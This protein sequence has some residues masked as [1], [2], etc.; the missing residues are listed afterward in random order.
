MPLRKP[1]LCLDK[2]LSRY[3][4]KWGGKRRWLG[5][6]KTVARERYAAEIAAWGRWVGQREAEKLATSQ[7]RSRRLSSITD[8][9]EEFIETKRLEGT[10][11]YTLVFYRHT[12]S[13]F[14]S[15]WGAY[16]PDGFRVQNLLG[17]KKK[18]LL[19][20]LAPRTVKHQLDCI[21][22][23]FQFGADMEF[24]EPKNLRRCKAPALPEPH[25]KA[26]SVQELRHI[27]EIVPDRVRPWVIAQYAC[28]M[29][30]SEIIRV[31][32]RRGSWVEDGVFKLDKSKSTWRSKQSRHIIV[33]T[34]AQAWLDR[35]APIFSTLSG[36][37]TAFGR[38]RF[39]DPETQKQ[40]SV[41][42]IEGGPHPLR[43]SSATHLLQSGA[44]RAD[45]ALILGHV[46]SRVALTYAQPKWQELRDVT[47]RLQANLNDVE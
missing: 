2:T 3:Y 30:P 5:T 38:H 20:G 8:L 43:H 34:W 28:A 41:R 33:S 12:L 45:I 22:G 42:L 25:N 21:R 47:A 39:R 23:L 26:W 10:S 18:L 32:H 14:L 36:Y 13:A 31:V 27:I 19:M 40:T 29:R 17:W 35:C 6:N 44:D 11:D 9:Y 16:P 24:C 46:P 1:R 37:C 7:R 4:V 15:F